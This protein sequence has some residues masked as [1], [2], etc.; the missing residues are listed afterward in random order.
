MDV[1]VREAAILNASVDPILVVDA[2]HHIVLFNPAA[3]QAFSI[4]AD[5]VLGRSLL[6]IFVSPALADALNGHDTS[7]PVEWP[8]GDE[9]VYASR[10]SPI[11]DE[12]GLPSGFVMVFRDITPHKRQTQNLKTFVST[13][14]HDLR[15]PLTY[16][17][18]FASMISMVGPL[19]DRQKEY[20]SKIMGG[21]AQLA[22][23]A[24]KV[25]DVRKL[26]PDGNYRLNREPCDVVK[27]VREVVANHAA[28]AE[29]KG[30]T[31][32]TIIDPNLP[33]LNLDETMMRRALNNLVDNAVKYT[34]PP[35]TV[36]VSA[37]LAEDHLRLMVQDTGLGI[38]TEH[39]RK[40][41]HQFQRIRRQEHKQVKGS[42]LGLYIVRAVS[43]RHGGDA[44]VD[45][46]EGK[47]STFVI[48][49]PVEG[50]TLAGGQDY[51]D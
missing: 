23:L 24:E 14:A 36:T 7:Q 21:V 47:G 43:L 35:G 32:T 40:L 11:F 37:A 26:D 12:D 38:S 41:F 27:M 49:I 51:R 1:Q 46:E 48:S 33:I 13:L 4:A 25:L 16:M 42:G 29:K 19:N 50:S 31:F 22:D 8:T 3:E 10:L 20:Q 6:D 2:N 9:M 34:P 18:G 17:Q 44:W 5:D 39:Q 45:S 15:S 30:L 28:A